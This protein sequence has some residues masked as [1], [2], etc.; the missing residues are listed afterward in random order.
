MHN[1]GANPVAN[2]LTVDR[3]MQQTQRGAHQE[4]LPEDQEGDGCGAEVLHP[5]RQAALGPGLAAAVG[6]VSITLLVLVVI[7]LGAL[8]T[9]PGA[10]PADPARQLRD[11]DPRDE[12]QEGGCKAQAGNE[13]E[14][15]AIV[16]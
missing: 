8:A 6:N 15:G 7:L 2:A 1:F 10:A 3:R 4:Q 12:L 16:R 13:D 14:P 5:Q 11:G 9:I